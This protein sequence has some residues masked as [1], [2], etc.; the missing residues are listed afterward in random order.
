MRKNLLN[1]LRLVPLALLVCAGVASAQS[2]G[3][4]TGVVTDG[5][6]S[7]PVVGAV[8]VATSPAL[9]GEKTAVTGSDG[10]FTISGLPAGSYKLAAQLGSYKPAERSDLAVRADTTLRANLA[11]VP[12][13]VQMEEIVVTGSRVRRMDLTA[14]SPVTVLSR[15]DIV[16]SGRT[17]IGEF[18]QLLPQQV[19]GLNQQVNNGGDG[20]TRIDLRGLGTQRTLVLLNGRRMVYGGTGANASVDFSAIPAA[21]VDRIEV[22]P[23]GA[24]AI[25]GSDAIAGV[26]NIITKRSFSGTSATAQYGISTYGDSA[27]WDILAQ[28]GMSGDAGSV[29]F[30]LEYFQQDGT[31]SAKRPWASEVVSYN[32]NP[33]NGAIGE[34]PNGSN[35]VPNGYFQ[36]AGATPANPNA[37]LA[38]L[39]ARF[40][41]KTQFFN[42]GNDPVNGVCQSGPNGTNQCWRPYVSGPRAGPNDSYNFQAVNWLLTPSQRISMF[43]AGETKINKDA[44][45]FFEGLFTNRSSNIQLAPEPL[46]TGST[47]IGSFILPPDNVFNPTGTTI[48]ARKRMVEWGPRASDYNIN[49]LRFVLGADGKIPQDY[50]HSWTWDS[51]L[52]WGRTDATTTLFGSAVLSRLAPALGPNFADP[53]SPTGFSCGTPGAPIAGCIPLNMLGGATSPG[54]A[55]AGQYITGGSLVDK[56]FNQLVTYQLNTQAELFKIPTSNRYTALAIGY[57][58]Q[59]N[60]GAY[61]ANVVSNSFDSF[62]YSNQSTPLTGIGSYFNNSFYAEALVPILSEMP[63][64][65]DLEA[66]LAFRFSDYSNFGTNTSWKVGGRYRPVRD[67]TLRGTYSTAFRAPAITELYGGAATSAETGTDPCQGPLTPGTQ[68]YNNCRNNPGSTNPYAGLGGSATGTGTSDNNSQFN[69]TVGGNDKLTPE[70]AKVWTAGF[71]FEPTFLKGFA[72]TADYW[73]YEVNN[74]IQSTGIGVILPKCYS[75][76]GPADPASCAGIKRDPVTGFLISIDDRLVN[77]GSTSTAGIDFSAGYVQSTDIGKWTANFA[78]TWLNYYNR[79]FPDGGVQKVAGTYD[80][81]GTGA[82]AAGAL[83]PTFKFNV[84]LSWA[85]E[86]FFVNVANHFIGGFKEC[87]AFASGGDQGSFSNGGAQCY[88]NPQGW[89]RSVN[90]FDTTDVYLSYTLKTTVGSTLFGFGVNN[91]FNQAPPRVY[92]AFSA[93]TDPGYDW[94]GRFFYFRVGQSI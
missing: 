83:Y 80:L 35:S 33:A 48:T 6:T 18:L 24:S 85:Y 52:T 91:I 84:N 3:V 38:A 82:S 76:T 55:Q 41:G 2:T 12:E 22:L 70:T 37:F 88:N 30:G 74:S 39:L 64:V 27:N 36:L 58:Y 44:R 63:F 72:L 62:D 19:S 67:V 42:I 89:S 94:I 50:V 57:E 45:V 28:T 75:A 17:T 61:V 31:F 68:L 10:S 13:A 14:P 46:A 49:S 29:F 87:D 7:K 16:E 56:G 9:Q 92:T 23:D 1:L 26:V 60:Q 81:G 8:V 65:D 86:N 25:Y 90:A 15:Q 78:A 47:P 53:T 71:V 69:A 21:A 34:S 66:T 93:T 32:A 73:S 59:N 40:P 79:T 20:S 5:S 43:T 54:S 11:V 77:S 51:S 4:I